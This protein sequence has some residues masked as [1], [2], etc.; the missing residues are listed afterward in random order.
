VCWRYIQGHVRQE[1]VCGQCI[2]FNLDGL[3]ARRIFFKWE[4]YWVCVMNYDYDPEWEIGY[5]MCV[6]CCFAREGRQK[7]ALLL[8]DITGGIESCKWVMS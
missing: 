3:C 1:K 2:I 7:C 6:Q 5:K 4:A 8:A